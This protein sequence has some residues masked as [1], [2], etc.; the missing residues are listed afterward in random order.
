M[1]FYYEEND[2]GFGRETY[3]V[4][5]MESEVLHD[6]TYPMIGF[7]Q[8]FGLI[9]PVYQKRGEDYRRLVYDVTN[10]MTVKDYLEYCGNDEVMEMT[11]QYIM[12][13]KNSIARYGISERS[14]MW[15]INY[16]YI[17]C[18][19]GDIF[20]VCVPVDSYVSYSVPEYKLRSNLMDC[21]RGG[22]VES[23]YPYMDEVELE[24]ETTVL[25]MGAD[26]FGTR[27]QAIPKF[28]LF[29]ENRNH[30]KA[31]REA[32]REEKRQQRIAKKEEKLQRKLAMKEGFAFGQIPSLI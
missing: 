30:G 11:Y 5:H 9:K 4:C 13:I 7:N 20:V 15:D 6:F 16:M 28:K 23:V 29:E 31:N 8:I 1:R 17:N 14:C 10:C 18:Y 25:C 22:R 2:N 12:A 26:A 21:M 27:Q 32:K 24:G 19:T 3:L